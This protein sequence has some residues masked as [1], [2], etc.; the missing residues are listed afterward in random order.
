MR[1]NG[2]LI[3]KVAIAGKPMKKAVFNIK[4]ILLKPHLRKMTTQAGINT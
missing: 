4:Q 1:L 2:L 3:R